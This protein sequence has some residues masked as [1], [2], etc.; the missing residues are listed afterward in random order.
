MK[1][2]LPYSGVYVCVFACVPPTV[3]DILSKLADRFGVSQIQLPGDDLGSPHLP[4]D[5]SGSLLSFL[6]VSA[7]QNYPCTYRINTS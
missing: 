4:Q 5:V 1:K 7:R 2:H 6:H 3:V